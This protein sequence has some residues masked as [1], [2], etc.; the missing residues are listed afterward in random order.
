[1]FWKRSRSR[2][3][4]GAQHRFYFG[5]ANSRSTAPFLVLRVIFMLPLF[6]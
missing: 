6:F 3:L 5:P 1:M 4:A 2:C